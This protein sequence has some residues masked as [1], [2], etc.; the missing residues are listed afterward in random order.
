MGRALRSTSSPPRQMST[1]SRK[2]LPWSTA[3]RRW[4]GVR[5]ILAGAPT[6][7]WATRR[8]TPWAVRRELCK[9]RI[10]PVISREG[11]PNTK[12]LGKLRYVVEQTFAL[13]HQF[14]RMAVRW[15][16]RLELHD[17]FV[18]LGCSLICLGI[19][20]DRFVGNRQRG[21]PWEPP[22][23][24]RTEEPHGHDRSAV[25]CAASTRPGFVSRSCWTTSP[26]T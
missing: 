16:R 10:M 2:P 19:T 17:A 22:A 23:A 12:G 26:R 11:A 9:R 25:T 13:L 24:H 4:P 14:K 5:A 7:H 18:S 3:S 1:T 15:E 8:T 6:P 21:R 20:N